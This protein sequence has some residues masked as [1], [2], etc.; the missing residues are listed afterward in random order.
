MFCYLVLFVKIAKV[1]QYTS[2]ISA[3]VTTKTLQD[4]IMLYRVHLIGCWGIKL[5]LPKDFWQFWN[6]ILLEFKF[7][8]L[9]RIIFFSHYILIFSERGGVLPYSKHFE[10][11]LCLSLDIFQKGKRGVTYLKKKNENF[12]LEIGHFSGWGGFPNWSMA[13]KHCVEK[14]GIV[15]NWC[16]LL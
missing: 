2:G 13:V 15:K 1:S 6:R 7:L 9:V 10:E 8:S 5:F 4:R 16:K 3:G 14:F 12:L 11:L